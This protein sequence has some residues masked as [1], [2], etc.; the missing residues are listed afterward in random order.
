M[1]GA[2]PKG[3]VE[4]SMQNKPNLKR[5]EPRL[6]LEDQ[7]LMHYLLDL[8]VTEARFWSLIAWFLWAVYFDGYLITKIPLVCSVF[9]Y[10]IFNTVQ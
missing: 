4:S 9:Y 5:V 2:Q 3:V 10:V 1:Y 8:Y 7:Q 6:W